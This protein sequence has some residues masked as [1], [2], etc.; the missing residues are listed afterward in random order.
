MGK[1]R[2]QRTC[3]PGELEVLPPETKSKD[4]AKT[5]EDERDARREA[6]EEKH[7]QPTGPRC[8]ILYTLPFILFF[9]YTSNGL[10]A[11]D[12]LEGGDGQTDRQT[13]GEA[14]IEIRFP[15]F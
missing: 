10:D 13:D 12:Y 2:E 6:E 1:E 5:M 11:S 9:F 15:H 8:I 4:C 7:V 3:R 14:A